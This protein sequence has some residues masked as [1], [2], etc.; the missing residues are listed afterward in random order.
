MCLE[1]HRKG[2]KENRSEERKREE[3]MEV[4]KRREERIDDRRRRMVSEGNEWR[5]GWRERGREGKGEGGGEEGM[6]WGSRDELVSVVRNPRLQPTPARAPR[7]LQ[8]MG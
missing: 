6:R 4:R 8:G 1:T 7:S 3:D 2:I 5:K